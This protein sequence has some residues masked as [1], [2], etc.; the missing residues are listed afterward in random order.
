MAVITVFPF[1]WMFLTSIKGPADAITSVP[2]QFLPN[3]PTLAAYA[4]VWDTL[5]IANYFLNST[6]VAIA[7][8]LLNMLVAAMAAYPLAKMRFA[9]R[10]FVFYL[11]LATLIVPAQLTYIPSF[12][13]AVNVFHYYDSLPA[14]IFPSIVSAFNI[15]LLRQAFR[16]V[17]DELVDAARVD[18]A[19]EWRIWWSILLPIIRP[20]LAAVA[21]FTFVTSWNDF[22]WPSLMLHTPK[23]M[24]LPVGLAALQGFFSSDFDRAASHDDVPILLFFIVVQRY[25]ARALGRD[26]GVTDPILSR[27]MLAF[28]GC[29][30]RR[31]WSS[32]WRAPAA[33]V[34]LFRHGNVGSPEQVRS[35]CASLQSAADGGLLDRRRPGRWPVHRA[36]RRI[37][38]VRR[39]HG[40]RRGRRRRPD[41]A[42]RAGDRRRGAG[43]GRERRL[44]AGAGHRLESIEP[45]LGIRAFGDQPGL[46]GRHGAAM[47]RGL[48]SAG[49]AACVKHFPGAGEAADDPHHGLATAPASRAVL[50]SRELGPFGEAVA[51]GAR[52]AMS[53]HI[54]LPAVTG[55]KDVPA[56]LSRAVM[57]D[58]LRGELG[59]EGV[60]IT[61]ALDMAGG[62][63]PDGI[64][65]VVAAIEAGVD[66]LLT[67]ADT[68]RA[69]IEGALVYAAA[70][71][72]STGMVGPR[73]NGDS[74]HSGSGWRPSGRRRTS[75]SSGHAEHLALAGSWRRG[76]SRWSAI[77]AVC[78]PGPG[79][80]RARPRGDAEADGPDPGR[81]LVDGRARACGGPA[82][83]PWRRGPGGRR[84]RTRRGGDRRGPLAGRGRG[85]RRGRDHR[86]S[87][88]SFPA[89][90]RRGRCGDGHADDRRGD[91]R[92]LGRVGVSAGVAALATYSILP[93]S[94]DALAAVLAGETEARAVPVP[95]PRCT[96]ASSPPA[97]DAALATGS[98][99]SRGGAAL[100]RPCPRCRRPA[101]PIDPGAR[102]RPRRHRGP[103]HERVTRRS[104]RS[105]CWVSGTRCRSGSGRR[106][107]SRCTAPSRGSIGRWWSASA[108]RVPRP[109][110]SRSS[111]PVDAGRP[112]LAITNDPSSALARAAETC[113]DL[114]AGPEL[115]IAATKT[116]DRAAG[117][118]RAVGGDVG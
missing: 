2:P 92:A 57:T 114:G 5:P 19:G 101:G 46:V 48:Q 74:P 38:G 117:D 56:T 21:I 10:E 37:D 65:D 82:S 4:R 99:S 85:P 49:V 23:G 61:D 118:R 86:R 100:P 96:H 13:L 110:W 9:G 41:R 66:L 54:A 30:R 97:M 115:A 42:G 105:T 103:R 63:G 25:L 79:R 64:P 36:G 72:C 90:A 88:T 68:R 106:R 39:E 6:T 73:R 29:W 55:R 93:G 94:L 32:G 35:L 53:A 3:D 60:S 51:A 50:S 16:G 77:R 67:A 17:P 28:E 1:A 104:T 11:L 26:Q 87:S 44:R 43:D 91:A 33:G 80:G 107:S 58:L 89:E 83:V 7:T 15:F 24:T 45:A 75:M 14:L 78:C 116:Y 8:G 40:A 81:H 108:S 76:R 34:T 70:K 27:V 102:C 112:T 84:A 12:I 109:T 113:I 31:R 59:F 95:R 71:G 52:A 47:V 20:S 22:L 111:R 62:P 18:G 98:S 69:G